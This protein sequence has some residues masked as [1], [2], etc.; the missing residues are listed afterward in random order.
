MPAQIEP[1]RA[2]VRALP[3]AE[4]HLHLEGSISAE[5]SLRLATR[6]AVALPGAEGGLAGVRAARRVRDF[7]GF[8]RTYL[9]VSS[10][11]ADAPAV[12]DAVDELAARLAARGVRHA[13]VTFTACTHLRRGVAEAALVEGLL[14][15]RES[16]AARGVSIA[17]VLDIVRHLFDDAWPTLAFAQAVRR[18]DPSAVVALGLSG[19]EGGDHPLTPMVEV[20]AAGRAEGLR[21]VPHAGELLGAASV[22][23]AI[24]LLAADRIGHGVRCL[25]D[26]AVVE[27]VRERGVALEVC[28]SSN[29]ALG[30]VPSLAA[31]PLPHLHAAG[32]A[33]TLATDDPA[34]F[35]VEIDDEYLRCAAA[36]ELDCEAL[37]GLARRSLEYAFVSHATKARWLAE[38]DAVVAPAEQPPVQRVE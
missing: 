8:I 33:V 10:C 31:H 20:F 35:D 1:L 15:G 32:L 25:E 7:R 13:E 24:E 34:L 36:F 26:P 30:V 16:A 23:A 4:L 38:L 27:L 3:K 28:P 21:S 12:T 19:P 11:L 18:H 22:R 14:A 6:H 29:V 5:L 2:F 17:Y 37:R 9:A